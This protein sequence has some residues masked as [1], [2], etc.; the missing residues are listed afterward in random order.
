MQQLVTYVT[1]AKGI[2]AETDVCVVVTG[3]QRVRHLC[4]G[5]ASSAK[6][7]ELET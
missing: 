3:A 5:G 7:G 1:L 6:G 4:R 2:R